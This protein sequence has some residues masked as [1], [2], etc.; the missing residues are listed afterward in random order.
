MITHIYTCNLC[1]EKVKKDELLALYFKCDIIPQQYI[2]T[3]K[4]DS[5]DRHICNNCIALIKKSN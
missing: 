5:S 2:L 3:S 4:I 1:Q